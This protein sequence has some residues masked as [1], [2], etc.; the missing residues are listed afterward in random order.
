MNRYEFTT[1]EGFRVGIVEARTAEE[2]REIA[3]SRY[4]RSA[5]LCSHLS[6]GAQS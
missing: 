2:A 6:N 5:V 1:R 3:S 4:G